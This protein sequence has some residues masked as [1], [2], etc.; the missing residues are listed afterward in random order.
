MGR[1]SWTE[2]PFYQALS[3]WGTY[4][5]AKV[6]SALDHELADT[7]GSEDDEGY[8]KEGGRALLEAILLS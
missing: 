8:R 7:V 4:L 6:G 5:D 3:V 2:A 1:I